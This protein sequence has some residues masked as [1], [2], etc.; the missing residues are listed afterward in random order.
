MAPIAT[1]AALSLLSRMVMQSPCHLTATFQ[2]RASVTEIMRQ[3]LA[4]GKR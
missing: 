3:W 4:G 2:S 1:D